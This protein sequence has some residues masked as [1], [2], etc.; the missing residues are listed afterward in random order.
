M[1]FSHYTLVDVFKN[2]VLVEKINF[3]SL[4]AAILTSLLTGAGDCKP[5]N[6]MVKYVRENSPYGAAGEVEKVEI[7]GVT[8]DQVFQNTAF[9]YQRIEEAYCHCRPPNA[10]ELLALREQGIKDVGIGFNVLFFLP[11]MDEPVDPE[12]C[13]FFRSTP[14]IPEEMVCN[15]LRY[16]H[17]Q[18]KRYEALRISGGFT[19]EDFN[20]LK[21]PIKIPLGEHQYFILT[22]HPR[23][24]F[25]FSIF[26]LNPCATTV[27]TLQDPRSACCSACRSCVST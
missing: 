22:I 2:P 20:A 8:A 27:S 25:K 3:T 1:G 19:E 18:N 21:L 6:F 10:Q 4:S 15:W 23:L 5:E 11:Q 17:Q 24:G 16:L 9:S 14:T 13:N 12:V 26:H 7:L